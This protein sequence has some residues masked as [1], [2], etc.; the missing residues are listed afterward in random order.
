MKHSWYH[1]N[2]TKEQAEA[3]LKGQ[4]T[5]NGFLIRASGKSLLL[6]KRIHGWVSH[7]IIHCSPRG[8]QL[9]GKDKVFKSVPNMITHYQRHPID[10]TQVLGT[11]I[12][13]VPSGIHYEIGPKHSC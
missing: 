5:D 7:D 9:D 10:G 6:S 12:A 13:T 4:A 2:I 1:G 8:Y 3:G 11:A